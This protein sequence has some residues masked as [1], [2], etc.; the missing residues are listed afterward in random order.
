MSKELGQNA[1][2]IHENSMELGQEAKRNKNTM[3]SNI[4][5]ITSSEKHKI[6]LKPKTK[7]KRIKSS[8]Q[9]IVF[10]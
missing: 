3:K 2:N 7:L 4:P 6:K 5:T 8:L 9:M 10:T 1:K